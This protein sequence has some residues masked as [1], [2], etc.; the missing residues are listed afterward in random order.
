MATKVKEE[1]PFRC[2]RTVKAAVAW[3]ANVL[4]GLKVLPCFVWTS[5][6][7][8]LFMTVLMCVCVCVCVLARSNGY[9]FNLCLTNA[10]G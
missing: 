3:S 9:R 6:C 4:P 2:L 1:V 10:Y 8:D 5:T 7:L